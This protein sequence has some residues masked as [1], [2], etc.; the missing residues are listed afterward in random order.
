MSDSQS[1][2]VIMTH[3]VDIVPCFG[4]VLTPVV[5]S[6]KTVIFGNQN[7]K[8]ATMSP[9]CSPSFKTSI[10]A[11]FCVYILIKNR[12]G[13]EYKLDVGPYCLKS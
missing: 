13:S 10:L 6:I 1:Y 3:D 5:M 4:L 2:A 8:N 9:Y 7:V 12:A 11:S